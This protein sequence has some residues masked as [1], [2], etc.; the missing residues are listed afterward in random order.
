MAR[1]AAQ[2]M[3]EFKKTLI[4]AVQLGTASGTGTEVAQPIKKKKSRPALRHSASEPDPEKHPRSGISSFFVGGSLSADRS[5]PAGLR[6][7]LF[8]F[9]VFPFSDVCFGFPF[10]DRWYFVEFQDILM[11]VRFS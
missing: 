6:T 4:D 11:F 10:F 7:I 9:V 1:A 8:Y 5:V 2:R 3:F